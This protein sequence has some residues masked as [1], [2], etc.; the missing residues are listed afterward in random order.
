MRLVADR[1]QARNALFQRGVV[2]IGNAGLD[3]VIEPFQAQVGLSR[4]LGQLGDVR[5]AALG[6]L[7]AAV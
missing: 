4:P 2:E 1:L 5:P 3:G 7:L 6:A